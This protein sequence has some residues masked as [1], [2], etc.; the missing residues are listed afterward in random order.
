MFRQRQVEEPSQKL[1]LNLTASEG[2]VNFKY[3]AVLQP[4]KNNLTR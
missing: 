2:I 4:C 1:S 3:Q